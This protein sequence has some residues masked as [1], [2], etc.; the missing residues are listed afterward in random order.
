MTTDYK[1]TEGPRT[2]REAARAMVAAFRNDL[3]EDW[4]WER[5]AQLRDH[6]A[7]VARLRA[8]GA[9]HLVDPQ[10]IDKSR[11]LSA[12]YSAAAEIEWD[13]GGGPSQYV[14]QL[15]PEVRIARQLAASDRLDSARMEYQNESTPW[16][17]LPLDDDDQHAV[18]AFVKRL[19]VL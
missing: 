15:G 11:A 9:T 13:R 3:R 19:L 16:L 4:G 14:I 1:A 12:R 5:T 7:W 17:E 6:E 18:N 8:R 2:A 10:P